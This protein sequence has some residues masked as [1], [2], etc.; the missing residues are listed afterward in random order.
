MLTMIKKQ[1]DLIPTLSF[2][3][4]FKQY[5]ISVQESNIDAEFKFLI[6]FNRLN[7]D[8]MQNL[9]QNTYKRLKGIYDY[10]GNIPANLI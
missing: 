3:E 4:Y 1:I 9:I 6:K 7:I 5:V 8:S 2:G 10:N